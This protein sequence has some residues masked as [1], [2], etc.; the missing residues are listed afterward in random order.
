M[1]YEL[2]VLIGIILLI[3]YG[4]Y[5]ITKDNKYFAD[6]LIGFGIA[7]GIVGILII[8]HQIFITIF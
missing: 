5:L 4:A 3:G 6:I 7:V 8:A 2:I 1:Q